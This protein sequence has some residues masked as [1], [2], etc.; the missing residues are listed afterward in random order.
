MDIKDGTVNSEMIIRMLKIAELTEDYCLDTTIEPL[1]SL[2][3]DFNKV[4]SDIK[5]F[6]PSN[7]EHIY[8]FTKNYSLF[9]KYDELNKLL[10]F[11]YQSFWTDY[12]VTKCSVGKDVIKELCI[13]LFKNVLFNCDKLVM[14]EPEFIMAR[15]SDIKIYEIENDL[16]W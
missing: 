3:S 4:L 15:Y 8:Y 14:C 12:Y 1:K 13:F 10:L 5:V 11:D 6:D 16:K 9:I 2:N 7:E